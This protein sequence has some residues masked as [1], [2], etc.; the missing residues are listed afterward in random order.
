MALM[1]TALPAR[2]TVKRSCAAPRARCVLFHHDELLTL[3][4]SVVRPVA[5]LR[6]ERGAVLA[7]AAAAPFAFQGAMKRRET[8]H[9]L[10]SPFSGR[11]RV[12]RPD[13][14]YRGGRGR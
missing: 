2:L 4:F 1:M 14:H 11:L 6:V 13:C 5:S 9:T 12:T 3:S 7:A 8:P 10:T